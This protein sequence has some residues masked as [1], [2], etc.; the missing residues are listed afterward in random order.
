MV[1][2]SFLLET[3]QENFSGF[4]ATYVTV[5]PK[6]Y[7]LDGGEAVFCEFNLDH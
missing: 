6:A 4:S 2:N 5:G 3:S 1:S 7:C